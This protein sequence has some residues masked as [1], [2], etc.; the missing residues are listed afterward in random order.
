M[1]GEQQITRFTLKTRGAAGRDPQGR[2][3]PQEWQREP[4]VGTI[5][6]FMGP[7]KCQG[8]GYYHWVLTGHPW[9]RL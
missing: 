1:G 8:S 6:I 5:L 3:A 7:S 9:S 2:R 4:R